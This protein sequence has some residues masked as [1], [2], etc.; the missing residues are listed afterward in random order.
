[1]GE[2]ITDVQSIYALIP[3]LSVGLTPVVQLGLLGYTSFRLIAS[4][5]K[6]SKNSVKTL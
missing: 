5:N 1:M 6:Y 4:K 2:K 3:L